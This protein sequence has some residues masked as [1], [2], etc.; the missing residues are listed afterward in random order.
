MRPTMIQ[1]VI[2]LVRGFGEGDISD[3]DSSTPVSPI[4]ACVSV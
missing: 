3:G 4:N 1:Q 2:G